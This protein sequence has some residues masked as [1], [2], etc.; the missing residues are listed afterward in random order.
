MGVAAWLVW[1]RVRDGPVAA[2]TGLGLFVAQL[3]FNVAWSAAFFGLRS[4][5][6]GLL[7]IAALWP[8]IL[9]TA[10]RFRRVSGA[11]A[12]LMAPYLLWVTFAAYLNA[13]IAWLN[14]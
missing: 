10:L 6:G 1:R 11:A 3:A 4:P 7:V 13:G 5:A 14:A 2:R 12:A 8:L 9:L